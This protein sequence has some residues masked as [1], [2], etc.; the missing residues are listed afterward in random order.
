MARTL[1]DLG[2]DAPGVAAGLLCDVLEST[3][4]TEAQLRKLMPGSVVDIVANVSKMSGV[5]QVHLDTCQRVASC[6]ACSARLSS[7]VL[8]S[9][10]QSCNGLERT[11][12]A[13]LCVAWWRLSGLRKLQRWLPAAGSQEPCPIC[14][15]RSKPQG[16]SCHT[17]CRCTATRWRRAAAAWRG[18]WRSACL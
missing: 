11:Q 14:R 7:V 2:V 9:T 13:D 4:M 16:K 3:M 12:L 17:C 6:G 10:N 15:L 1:A 8:T 5:C 18:S